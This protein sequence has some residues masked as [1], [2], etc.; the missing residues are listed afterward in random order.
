M[1]RISVLVVYLVAACAQGGLAP[2][3]TFTEEIAYVEA[4]SQ[5]AIKTIAALTCRSYDT[6]GAC[7]EAGRPLHPARSL[8]YLDT[9]S[10]VR[11]ALKSAST[12]SSAGGSCLGQPSTPAACL[13]LASSLLL[14]IEQSIVRIQ[15]EAR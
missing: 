14:E 4:G 11:A 13:A 9:L 10:R 8:A 7:T 5:G 15:G 3:Q 6:E 12:M 2:A 1:K